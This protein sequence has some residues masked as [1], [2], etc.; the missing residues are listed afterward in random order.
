VLCDHHRWD[1]KVLEDALEYLN[2]AYDN[3]EIGEIKYDR[4]KYIN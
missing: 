3:N 1:W 4:K 2:E